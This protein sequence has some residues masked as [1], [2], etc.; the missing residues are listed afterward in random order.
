MSVGQDITMVTTFSQRSLFSLCSQHIRQVCGEVDTVQNLGNTLG[1]PPDVQPGLQCA[2]SHR[3]LF[4]EGEQGE[5]L[6]PP[7]RLKTTN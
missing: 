2:H 4:N 6:P 5:K 1:C 7:N 3:V